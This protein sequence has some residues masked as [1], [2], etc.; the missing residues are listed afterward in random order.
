MSNLALNSRSKIKLKCSRRTNFQRESFSMIHQEGK[1]WSEFNL[2]RSF[3]LSKMHFFR[4]FSNGCIVGRDE[5]RGRVRKTL[6]SFKSL[7]KGYLWSRCNCKSGEQTQGCEWKN[8]PTSIEGKIK[9]NFVVWRMTKPV[10]TIN[11]DF[12]L[13]IPSTFT[14]HLQGTNLLTCIFN[15]WQNCKGNT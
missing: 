5:G 3:R 13:T 14:V 4:N 12:P 9:I 2:W 10:K 1:E 15:V 11:A 8:I 7:L 6:F